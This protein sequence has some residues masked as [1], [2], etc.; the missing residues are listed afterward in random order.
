M[1]ECFAKISYK[2]KPIW[3]KVIDDKYFRL[4]NSIYCDKVKIDKA[5]LP[6]GKI[7]LL[8]PCEAKK[9]VALA[10]NYKGLVGQKKS[11]DEPLL[12]FKSLT[13]LIGNEDVVLY[14]EFAKKVWHEAELAIVIKK[15]GKNISKN[16]AADHILGFTCGNDITC[17]N[18]LNRD[19]HLARSKGLD[20]FCPLG[21]FLVKGVDTERLR[22]KSY[23]NNRLTQDS[24]TSDRILNDCE[25]VSLVSKFVTLSAGDV[26]LTGTPSGA[27]EAIIKPGDSISVEIESIGV[28][29]NYVKKEAE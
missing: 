12:F 9:V 8:P 23:I 19:W 11:Y 17:E 25:I 14:P 21:P 2:G 10:Y 27:V 29:K 1:K 26:I 4:K 6:T 3:C 5:P 22:I 16:H 28:L 15:E 13:G 24:N 7:Q 20:T 18:I